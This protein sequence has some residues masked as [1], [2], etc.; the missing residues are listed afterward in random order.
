MNKDSSK[1][2]SSLQIPKVPTLTNLRIYVSV[3]FLGGGMAF[4]IPIS[5]SLNL[6][7]KIASNGPLTEIK[8]T[9]DSIVD[10]IAEENKLIERGEVLLKFNQPDLKADINITRTELNSIESQLKTSLYECSRVEQVLNR[11]IDH[12]NESYNLKKEAFEL[13]TI[14]RLNLLTAR[15]ELDELYREMAIHQQ[16]CKQDQ[17]RLMGDRIILE[18]QLDKQISS[19]AL[20]EI[21]AAP[22]NGYLHRVNIKNGQQ[23]LAGQTLGLFT[24]EGTAGA[25]LIIPLKDRPFV[26]VGDTY[27][28][29]SDSY[30]ILSN[31]PVRPCN[32]T[33]I[34]PDSFSGDQSHRSL[35]YEVAFEA[36]CEF[37]ESPLEVEYPFLVGMRINGSATS[38]K[39]NLVQLLLEGYRR[40]ITS[41][42]NTPKQ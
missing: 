39:S 35:S 36:Q 8:A 17:K 24:S 15:K 33:S 25:N 3:A 27:L 12:A 7:G 4:L 19:N 9:H 6:T 1:N 34:S 13:E 5:L 29:T 28:I 41:Q 21:I 37:P 38:V 31:P 22:T 14:S 18:K 10:Y 23:V 42:I 40:L 32:I 2:F 20:S 16:R 26:Q 30:Q 11:N